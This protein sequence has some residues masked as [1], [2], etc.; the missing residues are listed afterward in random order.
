MVE[1][2][3]IRDTEAMAE[4]CA[5]ADVVIHTAAQVSVQKSTEEP[6]VDADMNIIGTISVL[7]AAKRAKVP[8]FIHISSAAVYGDPKRVPISEGD[9]CEPKSF[10]GAS[11]LSGEHYVQAYHHTFGMDYII[12]R[13]F[14][15]YS[16]R[17]DPNSPYSGV[18]TKFSERARI[19]QPLLI[20]GDGSQSRDFI[21][22]KDV[23]L[24]VK[25]VME[26]DVRNIVMNCGSGHGTTVQEVAE[27]IASVAPRKVVI[28]HVSPRT[29]DI[30]HS[31]AD[32]S[33]SRDELGF[34]VSVSL[35][36]GLKAFFDRQD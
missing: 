34:K 5:G 20:E 6:T 1:Y 27:T 33:R 11:K 29:S 36:D 21:H 30:K 13:P 26:S 2:A 3:D 7:Q 19:G 16:Q 22:A 14:N 4:E 35:K 18:I 24:M 10:Y 12:V 23:A 32:V 17:A 28:E 15:F 31:V 25:A 8:T 9:R